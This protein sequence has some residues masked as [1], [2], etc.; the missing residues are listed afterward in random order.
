MSTQEKNIYK[1]ITVPSNKKSSVPTESR[2]Y[3]GISTVNPDSSG[4]VLYDIALI[5]QDIINNFHIRQGEKLSD[6]EFGTI[7]WDVLFEP[8]TDGVK[9]AITTNVTRVI[10]YDPRVNVDRIVVDS[11]ESGIQIDCT[12]TYLPYNISESMSMKFDE[13]AGFLS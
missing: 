11:Y 6:P 10:N 4:W 3:R 7:I 9:E 2:A 13:D 1:Q 12:L 8:L 5:K